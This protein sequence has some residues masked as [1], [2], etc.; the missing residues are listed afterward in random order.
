MLPELTNQN[1]GNSGELL[2]E[3]SVAK[4]SCAD[5]FKFSE[6]WVIEVE[7]KYFQENLK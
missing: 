2:Q 6:G 5:S 4:P 7:G 3:A 1:A